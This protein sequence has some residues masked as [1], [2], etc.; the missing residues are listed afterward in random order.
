MHSKVV[1]ATSI[2]LVV[3]AVAAGL[4]ISSLT[5]AR[6]DAM[7]SEE[8]VSSKAIEAAPAPTPPLEEVPVVSPP[9]EEKIDLFEISCYTPNGTTLFNG[10]EV[11]GSQSLEGILTIH[12]YKGYDVYL[13]GNYSCVEKFDHPV[14]KK[15]TTE[16]TG[17]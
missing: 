1:V 10:Y 12:P 16:I 14:T 9:E 2:V 17:Q 15:S 13:T 8:I 6:K 11:G 7:P 4:K 5:R 3:L